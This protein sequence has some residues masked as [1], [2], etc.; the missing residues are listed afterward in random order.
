[1]SALTQWLGRANKR[2]LSEDQKSDVINHIGCLCEMTKSVNDVLS[3]DTIN[4]VD[5]I[6]LAQ[7]AS[8]LAELS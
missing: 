6:N 1:M 2:M 7:T 4:D 8:L 5:A 3:E